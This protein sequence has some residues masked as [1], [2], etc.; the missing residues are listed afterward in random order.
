MATVVALD[1]DGIDPIVVIDTPGRVTH[2]LDLSEVIGI[3]VSRNG[4]KAHLPGGMIEIDD[5]KL[6]DGE[7]IAER[8]LALRQN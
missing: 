3:T 7:L 8:W 4:V 2:Y 1:P 6:E 5:I